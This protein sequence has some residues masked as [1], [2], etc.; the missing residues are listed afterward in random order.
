MTIEEAKCTIIEYKPVI[1]FARYR[2][3]L[4]VAISAL[5][6]N[7]QYKAIGLGSPEEV[8]QDLLLYKAD[9][10]VLREF[11]AIGTVDRFRELEERATAKS[12]KM[13]S[14][15]Y[16]CCSCGLAYAVRGN[17]YCINCGQHLYEP[18]NE[19]EDVDE[20]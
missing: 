16:G 12:M 11:E 3:A 13:M 4:N 9:R 10:E 20:D 7:Q 6:E 17:G 8:E 15:V 18:E 19:E 5:E 1:G 14:G 2:E